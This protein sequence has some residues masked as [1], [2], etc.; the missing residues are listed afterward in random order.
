MASGETVDIQ[1]A[2]RWPQHI[3]HG[4]P[5]PGAPMDLKVPF[6]PYEED[7]DLS[8]TEGV[9]GKLPPYDPETGWM[10]GY[11]PNGEIVNEGDGVV[12]DG[13]GNVPADA[14]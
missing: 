12:G 3:P 11:G 13:W 1:R 9:L 2:R 6:K 4:Q 14:N 10:R 8:D 7:S 5:A